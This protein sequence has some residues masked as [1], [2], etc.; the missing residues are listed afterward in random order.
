MAEKVSTNRSGL[1]DLWWF[2]V[3]TGV[4]TMIFGIA[5]LFWP[6]LTL[7]TFIYLFSAFVLVWGV[8]SVVRGFV[9]MTAARSM[10]WL[11]LI[12]GFLAI[13][14]GVYLV[15]HPD[16]SFATLLLLTAFTFIV[17]GAVDVVGG[18]FGE[19]QSATGRMLAFIAGALGVVVGV[20]LL[21]QPVEGGVAFVW[22][23][24]LYA[25]LAGPLMIALAMDGRRVER[26]LV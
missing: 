4:L 22:V 1:D 16:V 3:L 25:L 12:F 20:Y 13:A 23:V 2:G 10:W 14:A 18:L 5:A 15:R 26:E 8:V 11:S 9:D 7:V 21:M 17:R 6:G 19:G 24:G